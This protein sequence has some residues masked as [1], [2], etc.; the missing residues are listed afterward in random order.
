MSLLY[1]IGIGNQLFCRFKKRYVRIVSISPVDHGEK[2]LVARCGPGRPRSYLALHNS[3]GPPTGLLT[4]A[5]SVL[6]ARR[7]AV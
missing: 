3:P 5:K 2:V 1:Y 7:T 6:L 4:A